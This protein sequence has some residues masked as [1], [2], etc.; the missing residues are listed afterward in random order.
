MA[1]S[2]ADF[3]KAS[4]ASP[5]ILADYSRW[6]ELL[7]KWNARINLVAPSTLADYWRRHAYDSWQVIPHITNETERL[8]DL[9]SGAGFPGL[10]AAIEMKSRGKGHVWLVESA[11][12][13]VNFMRTVIRDLSLPATV[14]SERAEHLSL[15]P[16]DCITARAFAPLPRLLTYAHSFWGPQSYGLFLK[17]QSLADEVSAAQDQWDFSYKTSPS[18]SDE[19]GVLLEVTQLKRCEKGDI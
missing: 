6:G 9:G 1:F 5:D 15:E 17:G 10:A 19:T 16:F 2:K 18:V 11:G 12:K 13:K 14:L 8:I 3:A 4:K 7:I